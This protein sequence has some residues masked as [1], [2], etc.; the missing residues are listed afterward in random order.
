MIDTPVITALNAST[1]TAISIPKWT[2]PCRP[3]S[4]YTDDGSSCLIAVDATGTGEST[5]LSLDKYNNSCVRGT[6]G[7]GST[8]VLFYAKA[9]AGTP[10]LILH[11]GQNPNG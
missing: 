5:I 10:N 9:S 8:T 4:A 11:Y 6:D 3:I 7:T 1:Y 2:G